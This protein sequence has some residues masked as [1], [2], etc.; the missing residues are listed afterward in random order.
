[1]NVE[2]EK[3]ISIQLD[4]SIEEAIT[5]LA[6]AIV[7]KK[8]GEL[9]KLEKEIRDNVSNEIVFAAEGKSDELIDLIESFIDRENF[10]SSNQGENSK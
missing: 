2:I 8:I 9:E 3:R 1:M 4:L 7:L 5:L 6:T 10:E